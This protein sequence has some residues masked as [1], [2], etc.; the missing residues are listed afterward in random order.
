MANPDETL[1]LWINGLV[2]AMPIVDGA[3]Q[4][5][6]SDYLAPAVLAFTLIALWF[7]ERDAEVRLR[8]QVG[9]FV[10]LSSMGLSGLAVFVLNMFYFR[11]RP[12]V[13]LDV[14]LLFYQPTDSSFP[15]NSAAAAF[16][17]AFGI[18]GVNRKL[19]WFAVVVAGVYGLARVYAGVHY[20]MDIVAGAAIAAVVTYAVFRISHLAMPILT[21]IIKVG[22]ILRLA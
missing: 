4:I 6:A 13:D 17:I 10:A 11:P 12:F 5:A 15:A 18:W 3:A 20:P 2:G 16:G 19:G 8:Q 14:N 21:T 22:R 1:F 9:V 7:G